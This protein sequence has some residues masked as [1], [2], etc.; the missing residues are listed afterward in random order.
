[1]AL[2]SRE[3]RFAAEYI[4][5]HN[6][7]KAAIRAGYSKNGAG[8]TAHK[9]LKKTEIQKLIAE[10]DAEAVE[11]AVITKAWVLQEL[12]KNI[13]MAR[14]EGQLSAAN[15]ALE[16]LGKEKGMFVDRRLLG[17]RRIEDM[18]EEEL[19]E[20]LGGEPE[21]TELGETAGPEEAGDA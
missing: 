21:P 17:V 2:T 5:D 12:Q 14:N 6:G 7:T 20:F 11:R 10:H 18:T 19:L 3:K 1:M 13:I 8:Q 16:L 15:K 4:K 9:L